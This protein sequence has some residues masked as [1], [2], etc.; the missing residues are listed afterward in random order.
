MNSSLTVNLPP[1][2]KPVVYQQIHSNRLA[3]LSEHP[4]ATVSRS[5]PEEADD[6]FQD[7]CSS[8]TLPEGYEFVPG[9]SGRNSSERHHSYPGERSDP[10][11][12]GHPKGYSTVQLPGKRKGPSVG[13]PEGYD[14]V[15]APKTRSR[16]QMGPPEG[17]DI[18]PAPETRSRT[19]MGHPEGYDIV[20]APETRSRTQ[21]GHPEGYDIV[22]SPKTRSRTQIVH[23]QGYDIAHSPKTRCRIQMGDLEGYDIVPS[24]KTVNEAPKGHPEGYDIVPSPMTSNGLPSGYDIV[25]AQRVKKQPP[26]NQEVVKNG[27]NSS[28]AKRT[29][30]NSKGTE[31]DA[32]IA[33]YEN[34]TV[35]MQKKKGFAPISANKDYMMIDGSNYV[36]CNTS[37]AMSYQLN[38]LTIPSDGFITTQFGQT[39]CID[40]MDPIKYY[41]GNMF[42]PTPFV[43][44]GSKLD[45]GGSM[46]GFKAQVYPEQGAVIMQG[47]PGDPHEIASLV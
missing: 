18:V 34:V 45:Q 2:E 41:V 43:H 26:T 11:S 46:K 22:P 15:P 9:F 19:Q 31:I 40:N 47:F 33:E 42:R 27:I 17:Y 35:D 7:D 3:S 20:P 36:D 23:P 14:I 44:K 10:L 38:S 1:L 12:M 21:M 32:K 6:V 28:I 39:Q 30:F 25:P 24:P 16:T 29:A 13:P 8:M 5:I 4:Y 37:M